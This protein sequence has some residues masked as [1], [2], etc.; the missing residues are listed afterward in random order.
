MHCNDVH[1][2]A[3]VVLVCTIAESVPNTGS[4]RWAV[5]A[6]FKQGQGHF[7]HI[8]INE[9]DRADSRSSPFIITGAKASDDAP[10]DTPRL[11]ILHRWESGLGFTTIGSF[12]S[13]ITQGM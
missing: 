8:T 13:R 1:L 10:V 9:D 6:D 12:V 4:Y 2:T 3:A 7:L 5:P 11:V